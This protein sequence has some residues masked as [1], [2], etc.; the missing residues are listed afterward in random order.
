MKL[1]SSVLVIHLVMI[2]G[3]GPAVEVNELSTRPAWQGPL[4]SAEIA[5][6]PSAYEAVLILRPRWLRAPGNRQTPSV[7]VNGILTPTLDILSGIHPDHILGI[8]YLSPS[9]A[10]IRFG[11]LNSGGVIV[12]TTR[13]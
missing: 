9:D 3:C 11:S 4:T 2:T 5:T 6:Y 7:V 12:V 10:T 1:L 8:S 13:R